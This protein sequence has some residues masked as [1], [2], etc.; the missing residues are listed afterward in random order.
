MVAS[1][2]DGE[3]IGQDA[4][5]R[6]LEAA[7]P[8][9]PI[10][11]PEAWLLRIAHNLALDL[12]RRRARAEPREWEGDLDLIVDP[13]DERARREAAAATLPIFMHL[14]ASHR[15]VVILYD[16]LEA[17]GSNKHPALPSA[18]RQLLQRYVDLS[19]ARD[20][21]TLRRCWRLT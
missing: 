1:V 14:P 9:R 12:P 4:L 21:E 3:D 15:S 20:F 8:D 2:L 11:K 17:A 16:V 7:P 13:V 5:L 19:N 10:D 6:A 18:E